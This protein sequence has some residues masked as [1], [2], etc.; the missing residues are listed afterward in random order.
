[1]IYNDKNFGEKFLR[2]SISISQEQLIHYGLLLRIIWL[3][4]IC[5]PGYLIWPF[6]SPGRQR[7]AEKGCKVIQ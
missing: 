5:H 2:S 4:K 6:W 7:D 3:E 1:M